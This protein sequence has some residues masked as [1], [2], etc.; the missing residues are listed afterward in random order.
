MVQRSDYVRT[1]H[2]LANRRVTTSVTSEV[3]SDIKDNKAVDTRA[4]Q[5]LSILAHRESLRIDSNTLI[6]LTS[7]KK[8]TR[9]S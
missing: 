8:N 9:I 3:R 1:C 6:E 7:K 5:A 4:E 2:V